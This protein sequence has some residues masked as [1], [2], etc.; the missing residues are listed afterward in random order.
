MSI[1]VYFVK[2]GQ[3]IY[4]SSFN[5]KILYQKILC[6]SPIAEMIC[7]KNVGGQLWFVGSYWNKI[8]WKYEENYG[9]DWLCYLAGNSQMAPTI[10]FIFQDIFKKFVSI[11]THNP[12][13]A[14]TLLTYIIFATGGVFGTLLSKS[15]LP[16]FL[17]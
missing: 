6:T 7:V 17:K 10:F 12:Q 2:I 9:L 4:S 13:I 11:R 8:S 14:P 5:F 1:K 16:Y 15:L 3:N